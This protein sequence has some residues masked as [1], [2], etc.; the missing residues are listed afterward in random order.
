MRGALFLCA[1][2]WAAGPAQPACRL[3]LAL[4]LDVS[5]SV[6]AREYRLQLDG[7]AAALDD[8]G[9]RAALLAVPDAHVWLAVYQWGGPEQQRVLVHWTAINSPADAQGVADALRASGHRFPDRGTAIG[10]AMIFGAALLARRP[11]CWRRV[12]DISG[13]G[14][15]NAGPRPGDLPRGDGPTINALVIGPLGRDNTDKNLSGAR[16]LEYHYRMQ[17]IRGPG[18]FIETAPDFDGFRRAMRRKLLREAELPAL[19]RRRDQ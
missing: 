1:A 8:A 10:S 13:D 17:V 4:G 3:A 11:D 16:T 19:S 6:D 18:A 15:S 2:L 12:L 5:G 14:P 7:V 9:V